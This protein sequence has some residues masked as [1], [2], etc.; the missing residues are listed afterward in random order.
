MYPHLFLPPT[1]CRIEVTYSSSIPAKSM[2]WCTWPLSKLIFTKWP[3]D[4]VCHRKLRQSNTG[5]W[6]YQIKTCLKE[7]NGKGNQGLDALASVKSVR[8]WQFK[9][10]CS[11]TNV[12]I[13]TWGEQAV[14]WWWM[15][16]GYLTDGRTDFLWCKWM[17]PVN[18]LQMLLSH[19]GIFKSRFLGFIPW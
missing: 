5:A 10:K 15:E 18:V 6:C 13:R 12:K 14:W 16:Q 8:K 17:H 11:S 2:S 7:R 9:C 1:Q 4:I 19:L 3:I